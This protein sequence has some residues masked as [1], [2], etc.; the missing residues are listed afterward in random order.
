MQ[1]ETDDNITPM[2]IAMNVDLEAIVRDYENAVCKV[3]PD[4]NG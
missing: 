4:D 1:T 2:V 3:I